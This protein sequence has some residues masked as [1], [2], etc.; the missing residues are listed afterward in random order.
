M[1]TSKNVAANRLN[2]KK[3]AGPLPIEA[4]AG[5]RFNARMRAIHQDPAELTAEPRNHYNPSC[6]HEHFLAGS[7]REAIDDPAGAEP[8]RMTV[9]IQ[10][11]LRLAGRTVVMA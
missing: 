5:F 2:S 6:F 11:F 3:A 7:E 4:H 1:P 10:S 9:L 8:S